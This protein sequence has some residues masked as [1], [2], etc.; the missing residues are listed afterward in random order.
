MD[1]S[2][3]PGKSVNFRNGCNLTRNIS[4]SYVNSNRGDQQDD[5]GGSMVAQFNPSGAFQSNAKHTHEISVLF[6]TTM[7]V[8][9]NLSGHRS[10]VYDLCWLDDT[11]LVSASSDCTVIVWFLQKKYY[12]MRVRR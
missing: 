5:S 3:R 10:V 11:I 7:K 2:A 8:T 4:R 1:T 12:S 6:L 9:L